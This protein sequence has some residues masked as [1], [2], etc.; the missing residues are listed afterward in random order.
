MPLLATVRDIAGIVDGEIEGP[1]H[2]QIMGFGMLDEASSGDLT[3]VGDQKHANIWASSIASAALVNHGLDL[4]EWSNSTRAVIRVQDADHAM[5]AVLNELS[6]ESNRPVAGIHPTAVVHADATIGSNV[7]IGPF[8]VID[9]QCEI[10]DDSIID[11]GVRL[12][13]GVKVGRKCRLYSGVAIYSECELGDR[14]ILH[15]HV[16]I[17]ADGFGYRPSPDGSS[18]IK[19]PHVG[20]VVLGD[21]VEIGAN[22]CID[23]GKFGATSIGAGT[24]ID[25]LCQI[26]HNCRIGRCCILS[27]QVG[28]GGSTIIGDG[29]M[30]GGSAGIADHLVLGNGIKLAAGAGLM[31]NIPDGEIWGGIPAR[32]ARAAWREHLSLRELPNLARRIKKM[33]QDN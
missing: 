6:S 32:D 21:D 26:G 23:R 14:I 2:L 8:A 20:K 9:A 22:T 7:H 24:K 33:M 25:N 28:V 19:I 13:H 16:V 29:A 5:I 31:K 3:F 15:A 1:D 27:G 18:L 10:G 17:G 11:S 30:I 4:G 12:Q